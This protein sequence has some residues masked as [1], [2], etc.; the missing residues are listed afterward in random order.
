MGLDT[1][2]DCWHGGYGRFALFREAV[3]QAAGFGSL[4][5]YIGFGGDKEWPCDDPLVVLLNHS[6]C[7]GEIATEECAAL[8]D[9]LDAIAPAIPD[10]D[11]RERCY[12]FAAGLRRA[13]RAKEPVRFY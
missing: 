6:D 1:T 2:H 9:R 10:P 5:A 11:L 7:D 13:D 8:A 3:A 4:Y 12:Q